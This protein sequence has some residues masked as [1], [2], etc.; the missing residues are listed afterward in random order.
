MT[1]ER[2]ANFMRQ[3]IAAM[4]VADIAEARAKREANK[5]LIEAAYKANALRFAQWEA[6]AN[7][8]YE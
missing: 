5:A 1:P 4:K 6:I 7:R 3:N 8:D 2:Y